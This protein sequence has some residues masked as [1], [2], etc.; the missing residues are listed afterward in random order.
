MPLIDQLTLAQ[1]VAQMF[2]VTLHG[3]ILT[4]E[5]AAFLR[6]Y[7]PGLVVLFTSNAGTPDAVT[8][9]TN[10][11]QQTMS[12]VGGIPLLIAVDQEGGVVTRLPDGFT[13]F[14]TPLLI[15]AAGTDMAYAAGRATAEE[16]AAVG[17]NM[18]LA[19]V[20]DLETNPD[21]PIIT[22]RS[23]GSDPQ[24]VGET[25]SA[26]IEGSQS[27]NVLATAKHFPGH[28]ETSEDSHG[29]LPRLDLSRERLETVELVPFQ[30]AVDAG[31]AAVMVA[32]IDYDALDS[33]PGLPASL[34]PEIVTGLLREQMG[35]DGLILTDA[36]DMN[37]VDLY[38]NLYDALVMAVNAGVDVLSMGPGIGL[39]VVEAG[40]QRIVAEVEAGNIPESRIDESVE[41]ILAAKERFG[42]MN[43]QPLDPAAV[44]ER[45][46]IAAHAEVFNQLY[47][48]GATVAYD[49]NNLIPVQPDR[50][51]AVIFLATR[52]QIQQECVLY[53]DDIR[54]VGV[55]DN[56][57]AE[58]I[59]W[60]VGAA[61]QSDVVIVW[62]QD[63][64][65]NL[66]QQALV[67]ALPPE[68]T[69]AVALWSPYDWQTFPQIAGY[70]LTYTPAR[71]A[72]PAACAV[73]FGAQPATGRLAITLAPELPAG[74]HDES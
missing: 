51:V 65:R 16:L 46:N 73:L 15:T 28:G 58:Q 30:H 18:N 41:R 8:R 6:Q 45:M 44:D 20:A 62:T 26:Y 72:V 63:A 70:A 24:I 7:Q 68:K 22:R 49:R 4:E 47:S 59:G 27:L 48:A 71:P 36:M 33:T 56:P 60:A 74:S 2:M 11:Y 55:A 21:N 64:I 34:S 39:P 23:F 3:S 31:V 17:I 67:N 25:I 57:T 1:K 52:Y 40:I 35:F 12:D 13:M 19:P 61:A 37:A 38:Y 43:W 42:V 14:P 10:S 53:R 9:L 50:S 5:G 32:H 69:I 29:T 54:W 66:E